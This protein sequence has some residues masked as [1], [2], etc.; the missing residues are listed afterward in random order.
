MIILFALRQPDRLARH[1]K[2]REAAPVKE[3]IVLAPRESAGLPG[4]GERHVVAGQTIND[5]VRRSE[6]GH[7]ARS[8]RADQR[9]LQRVAVDG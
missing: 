2:V 5:A 9:E 8:S 7:T 6:S 1:G 4:V 3:T